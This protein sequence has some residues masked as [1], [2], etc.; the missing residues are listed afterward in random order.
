[1]KHFTKSTTFDVN[2]LLN[3]ET[4]V[5]E[6]HHNEHRS[7]NNEAMFDVKNLLKNKILLK[8]LISMNNSSI[9]H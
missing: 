4:A 8:N 3:N 6:R 7:F 1:M 5:S 9:P 2:F